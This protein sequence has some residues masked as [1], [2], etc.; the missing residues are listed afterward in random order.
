[1]AGLKKK[2]VGWLLVVLGFVSCDFGD[3]NIDPTSFADVNVSLLLPSA[4]AQTVKNL[5]SIG[6]R[7]TGS[8]IQHFEGIEAQTET[9][10]SYLINENELDQY[11]RTGLYAAALRDSHLIINKSDGRYPHYEGVAKILIAINLG[12]ATTFWGDV[13][14]SDAFV[15]DNNTPKYDEQ[16]Q[17]YERIQELLGAAI[18]DLAAPSELEPRRDDLIFGGDIDAWVATARALQA[19]YYLHLSKRDPEAANKALAAIGAGAEL[20]I[21]NTPEF[22][23][24]DNLNEA[25]PFA[26][27]GEDRPNQL[28]LGDFMTSILSSTNDPRMS[29]YSVFSN[30][31]NLLYDR[32]NSQLY[33][34]QF[35]A[36]MAL[37]TVTEVQFIKAECYL[38]Q[39]NEA[40][41][42]QMLQ[43][44]IESSMDGLGISK[45]EID[46]FLI[47][48]PQLTTL[49][50]FEE[51]LQLIIEQKYVAQ[52]VQGSI[53]SWVD[54]RRTGYPVLI[55]P[56]N[57]N[58]SFNP[59]KVVPRRYLY[60]I[61]E[62]I[63]NAD[64]LQQAIQRQGGH[65]LDIDMWAFK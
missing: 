19:R 38:R 11:W 22:P 52:F 44:A 56:S 33:W 23:Y 26:R 61:S 24:A 28:A 12:I 1:M 29:V 49:S 21:D 58:E 13:P 48:L 65:L 17:I 45:P 35:D 40:Q 8:V 10:T 25:N 2:Y 18:L 34:G 39:G 43:Q 9:Y 32:D 59:T 57:A 41:A 31:V 5:S 50:G 14:Y 46:T 36:P 60:P 37:T 64:N 20:G 15:E 55:P 16:Y 62:R 51:Q 4:Q 47:H 30:G 7:V 54:Y 42:E 53:E 63:T 3:T 6:L 27:F